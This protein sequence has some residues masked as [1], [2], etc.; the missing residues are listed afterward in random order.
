MSVDVTTTTV[1]ARPR[2]EVFAYA[3]DP[4][5]APAWYANIQR[6]EWRTPPPLV[7]GSQIAFVARFLGRELAYTYEITELVA[8]SLLV[9]R[10]HEGP[11]AMETRYAFADEGE[12]ATR[13]TLQNRGT[14][15]GFGRLAAPLLAAQMRRANERDLA[16]I[17]R[18]LEES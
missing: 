13:M 2:A 8:D 18:I 9:M 5:H 7:V 12:R 6:A 16:L 10:T 1:I 4:D 14:P 11:F 3:V 15:T 17:K